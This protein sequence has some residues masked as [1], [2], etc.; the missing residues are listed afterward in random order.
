MNLVIDIGNTQVKAA[1]F[2][3]DTLQYVVSFDKRSI[4]SQI[5][6]IIKKYDISDAILSNVALISEIK[7]K[8]LQQI[9]H[10]RIISSSTKVPFINSYQTPK[11]LGV[12]RIALA[13]AAVREFPNKNVLV[14][15]LGT[16]ITY[17]LLTYDNRYFGGSISPGIAMR[18]KSV[19]TFTKN[20]PDFLR[21]ALPSHS[22]IREGH[23][24]L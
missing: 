16:C 22:F 23:D 11:T 19:H 3:K 1:V 7:L 8:K 20:L 15:D 5:K 14:I 9:V 4:F 12:D 21:W 10:L 6:A 17:D 24:S 2:E 18:Y 13:T